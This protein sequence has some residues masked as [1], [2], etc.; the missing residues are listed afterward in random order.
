[1]S[2]VLESKIYKKAEYAGQ[3][4]TMAVLG[5]VTFNDKGQLIVENDD[6]LD[7]FLLATQPSFDFV[8]LDASGKPVKKTKKNATK[9]EK[10]QE[11]AQE[12]KEKEI[13]EITAKLE[14]MS[15]KQ[16]LELTRDT[17]ISPGAAAAWS[18]KRLRKELLERLLA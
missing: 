12:E 16:L 11:E 18:D 13:A 15:S 1:M 4:V 9:E 7:A 6:R 10:E 2:I 17:D 8:V 5:A 14:A 3:T